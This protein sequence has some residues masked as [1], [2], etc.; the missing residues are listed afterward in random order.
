[1][2]IIIRGI[3]VGVWLLLGGVYSIIWQDSYLSVLLRQ[4]QL[5]A[6]LAVWK[7]QGSQ[8]GSEVTH[9]NVNSLIT[10][11]LLVIGGDC[12]QSLRPWLVS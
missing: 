10:E 3:N 9:R 4:R 2:V 8:Q 12:A 6:E 1:M 11:S 7:Q 5:F